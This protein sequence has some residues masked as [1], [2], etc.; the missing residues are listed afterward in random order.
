VNWSS[1]GT[2]IKRVCESAALVDGWRA[3]CIV[4]AETV[5]DD[6]LDKFRNLGPVSFGSWDDPGF[7]LAT[8]QMAFWRHW[9]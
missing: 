7:D 4:N 6:L 8:G 1:I 9:W 2:E 5:N 3:C